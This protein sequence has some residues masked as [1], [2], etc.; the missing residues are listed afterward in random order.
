MDTA[1]IAA[2]CATLG[3]AVG[4]VFT[5]LFARRV[6]GEASMALLTGLRLL[7]YAPAMLLWRNEYSALSGVSIAWIVLLGILFTAAYLGFNLAMATGKNPALVG[8]VAGSFPASA[9]F[10]AVV[11]LGQ[12]PTVLPAAL[13]LAVL[14]GVLLIGLPDNW[15]SS[16]KVDRG[17]ALALIPLVCW[18]VF[19]ALI[20]KPANLIN[21]QHSWFVVQSLVVVIMTIVAALISNKRLP[22][23][24]SETG[25]TR[26]WHLVLPAGIIIGLAEAAQALSLG[27][28]KEIVIIETLLG[29]Y[30]AAYF[31][32]ANR[33]FKEPIH[34]RQ[35]VGVI[36]VAVSILLLSSGVVSK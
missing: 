33:I 10:V 15:R 25:R 28:G 4:D 27:S 31:L 24:I 12:R 23:F 1:I 21:T 35:I 16:L 32:I 17:I 14:L 8:V 20:N 26:S 9:S 19:G 22:N 2:L 11:F 7:L 5:A 29:S 18:G 13:L 30:P 6:S 34:M 36:V 3:F